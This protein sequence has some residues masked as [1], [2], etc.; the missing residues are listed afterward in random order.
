MAFSSLR[1]FFLIAIVMVQ[2]GCATAEHNPETDAE[3]SPDLQPVPSN[4]DSHGWGTN[5]QQTSGGRN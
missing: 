1:W 5:I 4:D 2:V 3:A